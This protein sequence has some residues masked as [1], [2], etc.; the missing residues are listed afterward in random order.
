MKKIIFVS[1]SVRSGKSSF[2][3]SR[4][5]EFKKP[6]IFIATCRPLDD[7]M[8]ERVRKHEQNRPKAWTTIEED[9]DISA[10]I[11]KLKG[12]DTAIL[13]CLTLWISNLLLAG[14]SEKEISRR[15]RDFIA[16][17]KQ[18]PA[19]VIIVSNEVGWGIVP[20]NRLSRVFRDI[21]GTLHQRIA[22]V[23]DEVY[24]MVAGIAMRVK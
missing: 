3:V 9:M 12:K 18:T 23:S 1:G 11:G 14:L 20:D 24:L 16:A 10:V 15:I 5:K 7:E 17:L 13:D 21:I 4:A 19:S 2:A 22:A 6:V 8:K